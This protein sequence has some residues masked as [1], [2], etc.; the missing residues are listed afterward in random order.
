MRASIGIIFTLA[1]LTIISQHGVKANCES[2]FKLFSV[3][4]LSQ[5]SINS[6]PT[7]EPSDA[8]AYCKDEF[9]KSKGSCCK[10]DKFKAFHTENMDVH[11]L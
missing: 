11:R 7:V 5:D 6:V 4:K 1:L 10:V 3:S 8:Y 2:P 9:I